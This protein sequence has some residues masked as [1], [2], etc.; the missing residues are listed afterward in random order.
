MTSPAARLL[1][2]AELLDK[3]ADAASQPWKV[4]S[5][6]FLAMPMIQMPYTI[7]IKA[8][9]ATEF[10]ELYGADDKTTLY[11]ATMHPAVGKMLAGMLRLA[12]SS[13]AHFTAQGQPGIIEDDPFAKMMLDLADLLLADN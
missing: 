11:I 1:A 13:L 3:R 4:N 12:G 5:D 7:G 9:S 6:N 10:Y 8:G 2:A